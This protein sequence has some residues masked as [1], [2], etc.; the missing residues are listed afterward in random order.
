MRGILLWLCMGISGILHS[1]SCSTDCLRVR[2][3]YGRGAAG[4]CLQDDR[5]WRDGALVAGSDIAAAEELPAEKLR[6]N[7]NGF[8]GAYG[9]IPSDF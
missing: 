1:V 6:G 8:R 3:G 7:E 9:Q 2:A 4:F 5:L